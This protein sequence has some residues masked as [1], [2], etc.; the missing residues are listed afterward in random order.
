MVI[1]PDVSY[2]M[3]NKL[4]KNWLL[5]LT[6]STLSTILSFI[7]FIILARKMSVSDYG[8][9]NSNIS[10]VL[11]LTSLSTNLASGIAVNREIVNRPSNVSSIFI[12]SI[13][14]RFVG[15]V[16]STIFFITYAIL[17]SID[18][19]DV[20]FPLLILILSNTFID[21]FEQVL[22][23]KHVTIYSSILN[24]LFALLWIMSVF[25]LPV[26]MSTIF[27]VFSIYSILNLVRVILFYN[28]SRKTIRFTNDNSR[29][30]EVR[31]IFHLSSPFLLMRLI[32][33]LGAQLPIILLN[34][35]YN[36]EE[37]AFYSVG[38]K[39][40]IPLNLLITTGINVVF[41]YVAKVYTKNKN[42][43]N[44]YVVLGMNIIIVLASL[45]SV[46]ISKTSS[47][48]FPLLLGEKYSDALP[49]FKLQIWLAVCLSI[50]LIIS[51]VFIT[52]YKNKILTLLTLVDV[53]II[54]PFLLIF[55]S[56]GAYGVA[57]SKLIV[58]IFGVLYHI[59]IL[60]IILKIN[61]HN[62]AYSLIFFILSLISTLLF[63]GYLYIFTS[64]LIIIFVYLTQRKNLRDL[65][66]LLKNIR[67][68]GAA[69]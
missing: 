58:S 62:I 52:T 67:N 15:F 26:N 7:T 42:E 13:F 69:K 59:V 30:D 18:Y 60:F 63:T 50:D 64:L 19:L 41:P 40:I 61:F 47:F 46:V 66:S 43:F 20:L 65:Y 17:F 8:Q 29:F 57:L 53:L 56:N 39:F 16:L 31:T 27:I 28:F 35:Y 49:V 12:S 38:N 4:I 51:M 6:S 45:L 37:A 24:S 36:S 54:I 22:Y 23:A 14:L 33:T 25:I 68:E 55:F 3:K 34:D 11:L 10:I 48:W 1:Q 44:K 21:L 2:K 5:L 9:F 32:G